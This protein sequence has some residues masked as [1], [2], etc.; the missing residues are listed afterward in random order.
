MYTKVHF[1]CMLGVGAVA[2]RRLRF[3]K[4]LR[5]SSDSATS[6]KRQARQHTRENIYI[7][8]H[9]ITTSL[10]TLLYNNNI[11]LKI[12]YISVVYL[13]YIIIISTRV[14][15]SIRYDINIRTIVYP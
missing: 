8:V 7:R 10:Y 3:S 11:S 12:T 13:L 4:Q 2:L 9:Y 1:L 15:Y 6:Y 14:R 5:M